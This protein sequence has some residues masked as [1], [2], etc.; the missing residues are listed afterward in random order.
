M[1]AF[2]K[3]KFDG[4]VLGDLLTLP[5]CLVF[6]GSRLGTF[7]LIQKAFPII[8]FCCLKQVHGNRVVQG[9]LLTQIEAD[10]HWTSK[11]NIALSIFTAD[12]M[13]V[14]GVSKSG[15]TIFA[16]HAGWRGIVSNILR[17][18]LAEIPEANKSE[19]SI[20]VGPHI[21]RDSFEVGLDVA[22]HFSDG[23]ISHPSDTSKNLVDLFKIL[24]LQAINCG[25]KSDAINNFGQNTF[26]N[27]SYSSF[28]RDKAGA[29][30][31]IS[32]ICRTNLPV[33]SI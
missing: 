1:S 19:F 3:I 15:N 25:I 10:G 8:E 12:C 28:R 16:L 27:E 17:A 18:A 7:D 21:F 2:K 20:F 33:Q 11:V 14:L 24:K 31:Q 30:R 26:T 6:F 9:D 29:G 32:F 13:P 23:A 4:I 5:N 22:Q